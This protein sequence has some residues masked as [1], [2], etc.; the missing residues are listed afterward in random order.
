MHRSKG[1]EQMAVLRSLQQQPRPWHARA[2]GG[3]PQHHILM[4]HLTGHAHPKMPDSGAA[5][6]PRPNR[7]N[8]PPL[9]RTEIVR[10]WLSR[11]GS[12]VALPRAKHDAF[13]QVN[14]DEIPSR[15]RKRGGL[16]PKT[17]QSIDRSTSLQSQHCFPYTRGS[18]AGA[19][20]R[21][22]TPTVGSILLRWR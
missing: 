5:R 6:Q 3:R 8:D 21:K 7:T 20:K 22:R 16:R 18:H 2:G 4:S 12:E 15:K 10:D 1:T 17:D 14:R 19:Q 11:C 9:S 13:L